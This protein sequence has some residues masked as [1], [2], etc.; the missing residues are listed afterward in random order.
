MQL[1]ELKEQKRKMELKKDEMEQ[2][3]N[4]NAIAQVK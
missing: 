3:S 2:G 1:L 4:L